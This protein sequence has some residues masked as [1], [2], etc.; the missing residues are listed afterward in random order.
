MRDIDIDGRQL[1]L[2]DSGPIPILQTPLEYSGL[3]IALAYASLS[4]HNI[5]L[6]GD[7]KFVLVVSSV[8]NCSVADY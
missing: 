7:T 5:E 8:I 4:A 2:T 3:P 6:H 1:D